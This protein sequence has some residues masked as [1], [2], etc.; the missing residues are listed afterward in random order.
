MKLETYLEGM[1]E[2]RGKKEPVPAT[3]ELP[4]ALVKQ[5]N[6]LY[7][8]AEENGVEFGGPVFFEPDTGNLFV[9]PIASGQSDRMTI[10]TSDL[11]FN[12]GS[13]HS[14]PSASIGHTGGYSAHSMQDLMTFEDAKTKP[15]FIQFVVSG[16]KV[17]AMVYVKGVST[18]NTAMKTYANQL[19][20]ASY[21]VAKEKLI[22]QAG[23]PEAWV[24]E[25][26]KFDTEE[27]MQEWIA[28]LKRRT[29]GFGKLME[30]LSIRDCIDV[31]RRYNYAFYEADTSSLL[32]SRTMALKS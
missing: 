20:D 30:T 19:K 32:N 25:T 16:S 12:I 18:F 3:L 8:K 14:H 9:N 7:G 13:V 27:A 10:P 11:D 23:G 6:D 28:E 4:A 1:L 2:I 24:E 29:S 5:F 26:A 31:A 17:Y 21:Q 15:F 22:K